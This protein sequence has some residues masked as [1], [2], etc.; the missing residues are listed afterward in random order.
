MK[1]DYFIFNGEKYY[2]GTVFIINHFNNRPV[3]AAF[4]YYDTDYENYKYKILD[5]DDT[6]IVNKKQFNKWI[7]NVT[8]ETDTSVR[9]PQT[10]YL[11]DSQVSGMP[12]GWLWYIVLMLF[13]VIVKGQ[14]IWWTFVSVVFFSWRRAKMKKEGTYIEW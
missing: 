5:C 7:V 3:K 14:I 9:M 1:Q 8:D 6:W 4:I 11:K 12:L 10:K 13:G 2:T